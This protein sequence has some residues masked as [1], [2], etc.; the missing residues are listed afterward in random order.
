MKLSQAMAHFARGC[1]K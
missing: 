1:I